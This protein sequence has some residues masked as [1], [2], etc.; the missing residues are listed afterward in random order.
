MR[1]LLLN[2]I[3]LRTSSLLG[4][5]SNQCESWKYEKFVGFSES[6]KKIVGSLIHIASFFFGLQLIAPPNIFRFGLLYR[7]E[8]IRG[9]MGPCDCNGTVSSTQL[10]LAQR[11]STWAGSRN[12]YSLEVDVGILHRRQCDIFEKLFA[13]R[14]CPNLSIFGIKLH[15]TTR[16]YLLTDPKNIETK[17]SWT[18]S[19]FGH[20]YIRNQS[21][22]QFQ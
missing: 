2:L 19:K 18:T 1:F 16:F 3:I 13:H 11:T 6:L 14:V 12:W 20:I 10:V 4:F 17:K 21:W 5:W 22:V 8:I 15:R 9:A 7:S